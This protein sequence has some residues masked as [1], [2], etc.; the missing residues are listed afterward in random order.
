MLGFSLTQ[1]L[2]DGKSKNTILSSES[3]FEYYLFTFPKKSNL[4]II[5]C[6]NTFEAYII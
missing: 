4:L 3:T 1:R 5:K 6:R 2:N